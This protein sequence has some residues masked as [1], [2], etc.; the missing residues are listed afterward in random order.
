MPGSGALPPALGH[1]EIHLCHLALPAGTPPRDVRAVAHRV[2]DRLISHYSG[3]VPPPPLSRGEHGKPMVAGIP[4]LEFNLSHADHHV[5]F[6]FAWKQALGVDIESH[7]RNIQA[8]G[9]ARRFFV[10]AEADALDGLDPDLQRA[11][12]LRVWT[13]KEAVLKALGVGLSFGLDRLEFVLDA[14]GRVTALRAIDA[15]CGPAS[16]WQLHAFR[17]GDGIEGALAWRGAAR[18]VRTLWIEAAPPCSWAD[19]RALSRERPR[20]A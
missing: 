5:A 4:G 1:D 14:D 20:G 2:L 18:R 6:A 9:L 10:P 12:F 16:T 15:S 3:R 7:E 19:S 17:S 8:A 13:H 11:A